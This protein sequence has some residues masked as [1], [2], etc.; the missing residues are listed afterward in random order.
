MW[1]E[2]PK[3]AKW[4][5]GWVRSLQ[6]RVNEAVGA[7]DHWME[8]FDAIVIGPGL[9]R[10]TLVHE[11][12]KKVSNFTAEL[13]YPSANELLFM[14]VWG[15]TF[16]QIQLSL[17]KFGFLIGP[18]EAEREAQT[19]SHRCWWPLHHHK[20]SEPHQGIWSGCAYAQQKWV[21]TASKWAE[22]EFGQS[23]RAVRRK[24]SQGYHITAGRTLVI[25]KRHC[26]SS[27]WWPRSLEQFWGRLEKKS[28]GPGKS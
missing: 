2:F 11:T 13:W 16:H 1:P 4:S 17:T 7:I 23:I 5:L 27:L 15:S 22:C 14:Q 24:H 3:V 12:V 20:E 18:C 21:S 25:E 28:R 9:G 19:S 6:D 10:D 8:R 26:R